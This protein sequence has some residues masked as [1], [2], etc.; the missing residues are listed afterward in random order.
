[1]ADSSGNRLAQ[2]RF[3]ERIQDHDLARH[4]PMDRGRGRC[5]GEQRR[6]PMPDR[7]AQY[8]LSGRT[9]GVT[10][11]RTLGIHTDVAVA[12]QRLSAGDWTAYANE[13]SRRTA[14]EK[15]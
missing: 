9:R 14:T 6:L 15:S 10:R 1:M 3:L 12:W 5:Q 13:V 11:D 8:G 7:L 4:P 2:L